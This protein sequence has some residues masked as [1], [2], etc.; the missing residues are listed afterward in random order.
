MGLARSTADFLRRQGHDTIHLREE[1]LQRLDNV[2]IVRKARAEDRVI[3]T[4]D[5]DFGRI[6]ALSQRHLPSVITFRLSDMQ[7]RLRQSLPGPSAGSVCGRIGGRRT[8]QHQ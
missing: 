2:E 6:M 4:H 1:G 3:L 5:L 8:G 7:P